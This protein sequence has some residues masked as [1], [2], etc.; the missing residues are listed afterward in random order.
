MEGGMDREPR[1]EPRKPEKVTRAKHREGRLKVALKA[2]MA[3]RKAQVRARQA[4]EMGTATA[5]ATGPAE[6]KD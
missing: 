4:D 3:K 1:S 5:G 6:N 2:N